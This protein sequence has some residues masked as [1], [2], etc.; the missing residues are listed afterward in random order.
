[1]WQH[2]RRR[3]GAISETA[4][5]MKRSVAMFGWLLLLGSAGCVHAPAGKIEPAKPF[6]FESGRTPYAAAICIAR[7]A[8]NLRNVTAEERLLGEAS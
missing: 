2:K 1:L 6:G 4:D 8:K 7:N 3:Y 5:K